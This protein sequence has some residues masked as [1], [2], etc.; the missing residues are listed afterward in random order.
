MRGSKTA[1]LG[2]A[3]EAG[4]PILV[5][6]ALIIIALLVIATSGCTTT[7]QN[8]P[9]AN[10]TIGGI[11]LPTTTGPPTAA[12]ARQIAEAA[13]VYGYPLVLMDL[14]KD[15]QTAASA[16]T[17]D[18][19]AA[20]VNQFARAA[21]LSNTS[22]THLP[23][24]N[25]D[26]LF[27]F[28]WL[29]LTNMPMVLSVPNTT[30]RYC[31]IELLDGWTNAFASLG[32]R[33]IG[34]DAGNFVVAGPAWNGT[35]PSK[36]TKMES[37]TETVWIVARTQQNG[38]ADGPTASALLAQYRLTPLS[39]WGTNYTPPTNVPVN[40]TVNANTPPVDQVA[41]MTAASFYEKMATLIGPNPPS[42]ADKPV[43]DQMA[44]IGIIPGTPF[45]WDGLNATMQNAITH[46]AKDGLA[47]VLP[48]GR[49]VPDA[50][51]VNGWVF[52]Y[53]LGTYGTNYTTR[54]R[55]A[56]GGLGANLPVDALYPFSG[57]DAKG[58]AYNGA[59]KYVM[60]FEK[61]NTPPVNAFWSLAMYNDQR[62]FVDNPINRY[63]ISPHLGPLKH[64]ADGSLDIYIQHASPGLD[65][66]SN[67]LPVP[68]EGF[69]LML[70]MYWPHTSVL[71]GS[72]VPPAVQRVG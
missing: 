39:A 62:L 56:W 43:V 35:L 57:T 23:S 45:N 13:Y 55:V 68:S 18:E 37:P 65:K 42:S 5:A 28:A 52:N 46:G 10:Q 38:L 67:W 54:A 22:I 15:R 14:T 33:T 63:A 53:N 25:A 26:M 1:P 72:W 71:N 21:T 51:S 40:P 48:A 50:I 17:S 66:E 20:P 16:P 8:V 9:S 31:V 4:A 70:R 58:A 7:S 69:N 12:E 19:T 64:N 2:E 44:R 49:G 36:L 30:G 47:S 6:K 34:T 29:N 3:K 24:P 60:H 32:T 61:N 59:Y 27:S 11:T 41:N